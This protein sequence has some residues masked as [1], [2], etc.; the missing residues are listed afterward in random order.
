MTPEQAAERAAHALDR[1][2]AMTAFPEQ[3]AALVQVADGWTRL[4]TA[5]ATSKWATLDTTGPL[6]VITNP[7]VVDVEDVA[8]ALGVPQPEPEIGV[9]T[10]RAHL[11]AYLATQYPAEIAYNDPSEPDWPVIYFTTVYGQLSWHLAPADLWL[12]PHVPVVGPGDDIPQW[13]GHTTPE[14]YERLRKLTSLKA[15]D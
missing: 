2:D 12:F 1:A 11:I 4:H 8:R 9:Y 5:L 6:P 10:E 7:G 14:K 15:N 13:D 3:A